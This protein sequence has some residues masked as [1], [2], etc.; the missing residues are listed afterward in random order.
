MRQRRNSFLQRQKKTKG[1][2][3]S[4]SMEDYLKQCR[5]NKKLIRQMVETFVDGVKI[6]GRDRIEVQL[7][8]R[9]E[10]FRRLEG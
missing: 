10:I 7:L 3:E 9:D 6:Y 5:R 4:V 8:C 1:E 2:P